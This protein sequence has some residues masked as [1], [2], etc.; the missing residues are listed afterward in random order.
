M[1]K[2]TIITAVVAALLGAIVVVVATPERVTKE[3]VREV[4]EQVGAI[5]SPDIMSNWLGLGGGR[6]WNYTIPFTTST[7][8]VC[9]ITSPAATST[10]LF[11]GV[12]FTTSSTTASTV[13]LAKAT[14]AFATT[15]SLGAS[16]LTANGQGYVVAS[17]TGSHIFSPSTYFVVG[18]AGGV[19]NFSPVGSCTATF[20]E[21]PS[22][23]R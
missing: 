16:A 2:N 4:V 7:T 12:L 19:G 3:V 10:L 13:T 18:M 22:L 21:L 11:G 9:A 5:S 17:T 14:T 23:S 8:T 15:T 1:L 6:V 20:I